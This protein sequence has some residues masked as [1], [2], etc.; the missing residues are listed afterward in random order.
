MPS[1]SYLVKKALDLIDVVLDQIGGLL[2]SPIVGELVDQVMWIGGEF[3]KV[4]ID[5]VQV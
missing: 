2:E 5:T 1:L 4:E 3:R